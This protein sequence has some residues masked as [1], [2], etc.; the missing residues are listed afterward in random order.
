MGVEIRVKMDHSDNS[1]LLEDLRMNEFGHF[2]AW[3]RNYELGRLNGDEARE[4]I[5]FA[6][7]G[8]IRIPIYIYQHSGVVLSTT[9]FSCPWDSGQV[10]WWIFTPEDIAQYESEEKA[11]EMIPKG[12]E[13]SIASM[14]AI[15]NGDIWGY[16]IIDFDGDVADSC[17]GF[18]GSDE[19]TVEAMR[20]HLPENLHA[21]LNKAWENR[22]Y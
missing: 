21:S 13:A 4:F 2:C 19:S 16:E 6:P 12:V 5:E 18:V 22:T 10:G 7:E 11:R 9:P 17:W 3:H 14:N 8:S 15:S 1:D 20:A